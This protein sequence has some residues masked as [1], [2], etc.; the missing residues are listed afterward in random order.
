MKTNIYR[1]FAAA[2]LGLL[3]FASCE[4]AGEEPTLQMYGMPYAQ[5]KAL[6]S[7]SD[8]TGNPVE[9]IRVAIRQT[10][11]D[12]HEYLDDTVYTDSKGAYLLEREIYGK[13]DSARIVFEDVDGPENG[14]EF[15][16]TEAKPEVVMT[17]RESG[18]FRGNFEVKADVVLKKK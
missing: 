6:G 12:T 1:T 18:W 15:E 10:L 8:E 3:G 11:Q 17:K 5:F 14:G 9:G 2:I 16:Q 7:V 4:K 13:T